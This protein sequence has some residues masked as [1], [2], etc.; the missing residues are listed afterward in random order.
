MPCYARYSG[1]K[2]SDRAP[3]GY[4]TTY[5]VSGGANDFSFVTIRLAGHMVGDRADPL[6]PHSP[7]LSWRAHSS[8]LRLSLCRTPHASI[9]CFLRHAGPQ[10]HRI[11]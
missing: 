1:G 10:Q 6:V 11:A 7:F 8:L 9:R 5:D 2:G 3:A 4:V